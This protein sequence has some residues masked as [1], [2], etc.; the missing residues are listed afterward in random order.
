MNLR[1]FQN[2][3]IEI[4]P[5]KKLGWKDPNEN[6]ITEES[7][8]QGLKLQGSNRSVSRQ[9]L[10]SQSSA[11]PPEAVTRIQLPLNQGG[12]DAQADHPEVLIA[13]LRR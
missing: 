2:K 8:L 7:I 6:D 5:A 13:F 12:K 1:K 9:N 10:A 3:L 4:L 11:Y